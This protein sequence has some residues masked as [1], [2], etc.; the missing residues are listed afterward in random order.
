MLS[1][2]NSAKKLYFYDNN[3]DWVFETPV[4]EHDSFVVIYRWLH[5]IMNICDL[6][7]PTGFHK[8]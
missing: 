5:P 8:F 1:V 7:A 4:L 2:P 6:Q 3:V